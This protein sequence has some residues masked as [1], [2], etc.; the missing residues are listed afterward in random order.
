M[1]APCLV[2]VK[3]RVRVICGSAR[4]S[5]SSLGLLACVDVDQALFDALDGRR[6][7]SHFDARRI[8]QQTVGEACDF[9]RH[10]GREEQVLALGRQH[11]DDACG[12]VDEAQIEHLVDFVE[13]EDLDLGKVDS[14]PLDQIDE[15]ARR[16]DEDVD[17]VAQGRGSGC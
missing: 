15:A 11:A 4:R 10:G 17:A 16:G 12:C 1:S 7:R 13:H 2:R 8:F 6:D 3:T 5:A 9:L 14:A